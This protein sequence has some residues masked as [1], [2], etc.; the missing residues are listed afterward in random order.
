MRLLPGIELCA[1]FGGLQVIEEVKPAS[2]SGAE[3]RAAGAAGASAAKAEP[4]RAMTSAAP[5]SPARRM[6]L[7][8]FAS[9]GRVLLSRGALR[10]FTLT[11]NSEFFIVS[12]C[13][14]CFISGTGEEL[15]PCNGFSELHLRRRN[16]RWGL[17]SRFRRCSA[18]LFLF[19]LWVS[20]L[21]AAETVEREPDFEGTAFTAS[22]KSPYSRIRCM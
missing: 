17:R 3:T 2:N 4:A 7:R 19:W 22:W 20:S 1:G 21:N 14:I 12:G 10:R 6:L 18:T 5:R 15:M 16:R 9:S 8:W 11:I 13:E